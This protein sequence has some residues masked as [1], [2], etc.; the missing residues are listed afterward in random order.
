MADVGLLNGA[1]PARSPGQIEDALGIDPHDAGAGGVHG[2]QVAAQDQNPHGFGSP[3]DGPVPLHADNAVNDGQLRFDRGGDVQD[4]AFDARVV[5]DVFGPAVITAGHDPEEIFQR[6]GHSGPVVGLHLGQRDDPVHLLQGLR[7]GEGAHGGGPESIG[8]RV[9]R[10]IIQVH[11]G[12][13][14]FRKH[15]RQTR[16]FQDQQGIPAVAHAFGHQHPGRAQVQEGLQCAPDHQGMSG[17]MFAPPMSLHQIGF[18]Q[19]DLAPDLPGA[20]PQLFKAP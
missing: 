11:K 20:Y 13:P 9:N 19:D 4:G 7:Q 5:E 14:V 18:E 3:H 15:L 10:V 6:Q 17:D 12:H 2:R 8:H 1:Q 16:F